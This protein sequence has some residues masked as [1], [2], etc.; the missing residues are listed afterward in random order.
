MC[1]RMC[2]LGF[3]FILLKSLRGP[4]FPSRENGKRGLRQLHFLTHAQHGQYLATPQSVRVFIFFHFNFIVY[5][6]F[7]I[8]PPCGDGPPWLWVREKKWGENTFFKDKNDG[9]KT[10]L[11]RKIKGQKLFFTM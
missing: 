2:V 9:T 3:I 7:G 10:F 8:R 1:V 5:S 4:P 6:F 11:I